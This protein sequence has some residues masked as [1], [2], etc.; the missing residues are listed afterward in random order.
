MLGKYD[1][2]QG[3]V[4]I[5]PL[6]QVSAFSTVLK[7]MYM[8][9]E[10]DVL[11]RRLRWAFDSPQLLVIPRAGLWE[12]AYYERDSRS[13]QFF[14][15]K[16]PFN[17]Q[18]MIHTSLSRDIVA[19]ETGHAVL[20]GICPHLY[21]AITPQS[22]AL[23]EAIA[24]ITALLMSIRSRKLVELVLKQTGGSIDQSTHFSSIAEQFGMAMGQSA[25]RNL[26]NH[27]TLDEVNPVEPHALSEV[28]TGAFY[29]MLMN[30]FNRR[31]K[32]IAEKQGVSEYSASGKA[33]VDSGN[34]F[35]RMLLRALDYLP[36]G[37]VSFADY[38]R[39]FIAADQVFHP[40]DTEERDWIR[41]E[42]VRRKIIAQESDLQVPVQ[43]CVLDKVDLVDLL[44]SN[45]AAYEFANQNRSLLGIPNGISF[46][47][48][49][50]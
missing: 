16:N 23:H 48:D 27:K 38:G 50:V 25:L 39:A 33:L 2:D 44:D 29:S 7:T 19:H 15:F 41:Q 35:K 1:V 43:D 12:N 32:E 13:L 11:G 36:P 45:W 24:D 40:E 37:E 17:L 34:Q 3:E 14:S 28:L 20:D 46:Q 31:K 18:E 26:L 21:N 9:E 42:F 30:I 5:T 49:R 22:L 4:E 6:N 10:P 47:V 8:Y